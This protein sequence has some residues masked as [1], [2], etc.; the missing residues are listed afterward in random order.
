[1]DLCQIIGDNWPTLCG[2][3]ADVH[4]SVRV[5]I[6]E[7]LTRTR[8]EAAAY[9]RDLKRRKLI[10]DTWTRDGVVYLKRGSNVQRATTKSEIEMLF[11]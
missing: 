6:N 7:D 1:M 9:S 2:N 11:K 5:Y 8:A 4:R 3:N 10:D